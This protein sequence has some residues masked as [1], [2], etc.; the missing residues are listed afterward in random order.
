MQFSRNVM[1]PLYSTEHERLN[2][3]CHDFE[4]YFSLYHENSNAGA[5]RNYISHQ[6]LTIGTIR[7]N[8]ITIPIE[9]K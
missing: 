9:S 8:W 4:V 6:K 5:S 2:D 7:I 3:I 1:Q